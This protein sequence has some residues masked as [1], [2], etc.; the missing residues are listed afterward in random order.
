M[1]CIFFFSISVARFISFLKHRRRQ[2]CTYNDKR[3]MRS[4]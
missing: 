2:K 4:I 1:L 3:S